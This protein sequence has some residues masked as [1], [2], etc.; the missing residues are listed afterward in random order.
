MGFCEKL[1]SNFYLY[2]NY[3]YIYNLYCIFIP[4]PI[5]RGHLTGLEVSLACFICSKELVK[6]LAS[7]LL[8]FEHVEFH[9][10]V[11]LMF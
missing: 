9:M 1:V 7:L 2:R 4:L 6:S 11:N 5:S 8:S 3:I 10:P